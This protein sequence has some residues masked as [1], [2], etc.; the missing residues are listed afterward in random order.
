M[1]QGRRDASGDGERGRSYRE[2]GRM[3]GRVLS[4]YPTGKQ[5]L[6]YPGLWAGDKYV[7]SSRW[8]PSYTANAL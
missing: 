4:M 5:A 1:V 7:G 8:S 3:S 2:A 6:R